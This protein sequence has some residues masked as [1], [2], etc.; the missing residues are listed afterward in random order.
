[1]KEEN[2]TTTWCC[3]RLGIVALLYC[4]KEGAWNCVVVY[5]QKNGKDV[6]HT[7]GSS[8]ST[9]LPAN[10]IHYQ[11]LSCTERGGGGTRDGKHQANTRK[12]EIKNNRQNKTVEKMLAEATAICIAL[13]DKQVNFSFFC[14]HSKVKK[15]KCKQAMGLGRRM[16]KCALYTVTV[17]PTLKYE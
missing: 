2:K 10:S 1:M 7:L 4:T 8:T 17:T 12:V 3:R 14:T 16:V 13:L 5:K 6:T 15:E 9:L 11:L